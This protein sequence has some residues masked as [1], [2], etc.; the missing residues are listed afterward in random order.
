MQSLA[1]FYSAITGTI[2]ADYFFGFVLVVYSQAGL[3]KGMRNRENE[4]RVIEGTNKIHW[5][6]LTV[7]SHLLFL[8]CFQQV[9]HKRHIKRPRVFNN[10]TGPYWPA[11]V[12][13]LVPRIPCFVAPDTPICA[14]FGP[15]DL[16][17]TGGFL[18][19]YLHSLI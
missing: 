15:T 19:L 9:T 7:A 18:C 17:K 6:E 12:F 10:L 14:R 13:G 4:D 2:C 1:D 3:G 11:G 8:M 5:N 16:S